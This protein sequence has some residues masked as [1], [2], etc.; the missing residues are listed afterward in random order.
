VPEVAGTLRFRSPTGRWVIAASV[1]GS[2]IAALDA[3]VVGIAL[4]TIGRG[5][6]VGVTALQWVVTGYYLTLASLLLLGGSLSDRFGRRRV[7]SVGV[8]WFALASAAC[9]LAPNVDVLV[10]MRLL[11]GAGGALLVPGSLAILQASFAPED[12]GPAIGA[13]SGLGGVATAAGPLLG[14]Y[15]ISA[16]SWRWIFFLNIP[17]A[18]AALALTA[19]YVPE[20]RDPGATGAIDLGGA[21]SAVLGLGGLAYGLIEGPSLGWSSGTV[22]TSLALS[23]AS[24]GAFWVTERRVQQPMMP[25]TLFRRRQFSATNGVTFVVYAALGGAL[26]LLP[27]ELQIASRYSPLESGLALLPVTVIMLMFSA[28]SGRLASRIGPRLQMSV[29]PLVLAVSLLMLTRATE[30]RSYVLFV[31]PAVVVLGLGVAIMVAP[32]TATAMASA[33]SE[34]AGVASAV[35]NDVARIGGLIAVAVLPSIAG[36][37]GM[38]Y[39]HAADLS[40]AF[41]TAMVVSALACGAGG[42]LAALTVANPA[43]MHEPGNECLHCALDGPPLRTRA[44]EGVP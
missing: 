5:F 16:A 18:A 8:V 4:P 41:R 31:L 28:R 2:S 15:L 33:G 35:N 26:F 10:A 40:A 9:G 6:D 12:Q 1:M 19:R 37:T 29:G 44:G 25:L 39:L 11:Q 42:A 30:G 38:S 22:L 7:F 24:L 17:V 20:S 36:I 32:L 23:L 14:G 34:H 43:R 3:T 13:W 21:V 27:V